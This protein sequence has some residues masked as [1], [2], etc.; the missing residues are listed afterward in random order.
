MTILKPNKNQQKSFYNKAKIHTQDNIISLQS[1]DT[2]VLTYNTTT[3][4]LTKLWHGYSRTTMEHIIAFVRQ[5]TNVPQTTLLNK[6]WWDNLSQ[7]PHTKYGVYCVS[8]GQK[9]KISVYFDDENMA[10]EYA[11]KLNEKSSGFWWYHVEE[12][13][14]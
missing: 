1:Y 5:Y 13:R 9:G 8:C 7:E 11:D 10:Y 4:T 2:I 3:Q 12:I 14:G 6:K